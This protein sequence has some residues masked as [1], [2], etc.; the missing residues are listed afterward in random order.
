MDIFHEASFKTFGGKT[1]IG[2][3]DKQITIGDIFMRMG[4]IDDTKM[5]ILNGKRVTA[6]DKFVS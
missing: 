5:A 3:I 4:L 2:K 1:S 6:R